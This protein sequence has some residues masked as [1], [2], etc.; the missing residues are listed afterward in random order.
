MLEY[1]RNSL[2]SRLSDLERQSLIQKDEIVCLR[3]NLADA[4]RRIAQLESQDKLDAGRSERKG[5]RTTSSS[6]KNG[7]ISLKSKNFIPR[8]LKEPLMIFLLYA[9]SYEHIHLCFHSN[10]NYNG[11]L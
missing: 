6:P 4:L 3:A 9:W 8:K 10:N 5:K 11:K 7:H 1:D 2:L